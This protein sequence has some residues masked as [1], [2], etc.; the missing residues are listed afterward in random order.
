MAE[1]TRKEIASSRRWP[2]LL[3]EEWT[4]TRDTVHM[5]TQIIGKIRLARAP[6]INHWWQVTLYVSPR[7]LTTSAMP[8]EAGVFDIEFDFNEH[9]LHIRASD[10]DARQVALEPKPVADFY[11]ETMGALDELGIA[12]QIQAK[13]NEVDPAIPFADDYE[14]ASYD[15]D[16]VH[17]FWRQLVAAHR[18]MSEFRSYFIGKVS[19]VHFFW[20][21]HGSGLHQ[22]LRP[23]R[24][25]A[26]WWCTQLR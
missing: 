7:G 17:L 10:G 25:E 16:A 2:R 23:H 24:P 18:V 6:M 12:V 20:G 8:Y 5:W 13:P 15:R 3:V 22:V 4:A 14:H 26:S 19:P 21:G 11:A 1:T 9:R